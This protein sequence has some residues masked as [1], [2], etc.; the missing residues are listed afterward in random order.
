MSQDG[1]DRRGA[2]DFRF[3]ISDFKDALLFGTPGGKAS[4]KRTGPVRKRAELLAGKP[5]LQAA[6]WREPGGLP[7]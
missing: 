6:Y 4:N 3:E 2:G 1:Q 7:P 5:A